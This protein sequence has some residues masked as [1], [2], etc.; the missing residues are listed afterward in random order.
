L[1]IKIQVDEISLSTAVAEVVGIDEDGD[2]Y[3]SGERT[4]GDLVAKEIVDRIIANRDSH[5]QTLRERV[6]DIR[7]EL[8]RE[9]VQPAIEEA[10]ARP[11]VK[12]NSYG[13]PVGESTT[14]R[15]LIV[16]EARKICREPADKYRREQGSILTKLVADEVRKALDAEI[17]DAVKQAREQ[18]STEIGSLVAASVQ[19]GLKAR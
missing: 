15:E 8:I 6:R 10:V 7:A 18:V 3:P 16:E 13:E 1:N 19:S 2:P 17:K 11:I 12:T 14:L 9:A 5:W 4:V